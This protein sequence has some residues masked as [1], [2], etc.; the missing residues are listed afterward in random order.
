M[1]SVMHET[2]CPAR[3]NPASA[4]SG[5][6]SAPQERRESGL[7]LLQAWSPIQ[8]RQGDVAEVI[9]IGG[10][11]RSDQVLAGHADE[12]PGDRSIVDQGTAGVYVRTNVGPV[13]VGLT[14]FN[15][16]IGANTVT[17]APT[18]IARNMTDYRVKL[19][20]SSGK[21][22]DI[23]IL[24]M[25]KEKGDL[26]GVAALGNPEYPFVNSGI[27]SPKINVDKRC[28]SVGALWPE[29]WHSALLPVHDAEQEV[30]DARQR[31]SQRKGHDLDLGRR[32][33]NQ[34]L[35]AL[36]STH[37]AALDGAAPTQRG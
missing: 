29:W 15:G 1:P 20:Q 6:P 16:K 7:Q 10:L 3:W 17:G 14:V 34:L 32:R 28:R 23:G 8:I 11:A 24:G 21:W 30:L 2:R 19:T 18:S 5:D 33:S 27:K 13:G 9:E 37:C 4:F 22:S 35:V 31:R 26:T 12:V 36:E 25:E